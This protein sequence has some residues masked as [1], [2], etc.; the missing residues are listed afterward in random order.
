MVVDEVSLRCPTE[1]FEGC[2]RWVML[3]TPAFYFINTYVPN[4]GEGLKNLDTRLND[5]EKSVREYLQRLRETKPVIYSG[6]LNVV[7]DLPLDIYNPT[8]KHLLKQ[9]GC[10]VEER[11]AFGTLLEGG[12]H[13]ALR[14]LYP[15]AKGQFTYWSL[16]SDARPSNS[17]MRL[18]YFVCSEDLFDSDALAAAAAATADTDADADADTGAPAASSSSS[19]SSS[20]ASSGGAKRTAKDAA[21]TGF[22]RVIDTFILLEETMGYSDHAPVVLILQVKE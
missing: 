13:D 21:A 14:V 11:A 4:S 1:E 5:W 15:T 22:P 16:R 10:T 12:F 19:S 6:D 2:G 7:A 9:P 20:S 17:G 8:D 18:D 3:D